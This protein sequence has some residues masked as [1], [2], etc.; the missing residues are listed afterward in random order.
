MSKF[1]KVLILCL[2]IVACIVFIPYPK[3]KTAVT[4][5]ETENVLG[6]TRMYFEID[7]TLSTTQLDSLL[8]ADTLDVLNR[9]IKSK[10]GVRTQYMFIRSLEKD[11]EVIYTVTTTDIDTLF[12]CVKRITKE[13]DE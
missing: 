7:D 4:P 1:T 6:Y 10:F 2:V 13:I 11:N 9:W 3:Q 8:K 5:P 12:K